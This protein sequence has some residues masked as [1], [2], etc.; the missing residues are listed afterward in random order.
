MSCCNFLFWQPLVK[1]KLKNVF[2]QF[3][4]VS[5]FNLFKVQKRSIPEAKELLL[6]STCRK[7]NSGRD[8]RTVKNGQTCFWSPEKYLIQNCRT[9]IE[10]N[11][12]HYYCQENFLARLS[13][14]N[15]TWVILYDSCH[16]I[17]IAWLNNLFESRLLPKPWQR[18][19]KSSRFVQFRFVHIFGQNVC[20]SVRTKEYRNIEH[21]SWYLCWDSGLEVLAPSGPIFTRLGKFWNHSFLWYHVTWLMSHDWFTFHIKSHFLFLEWPLFYLQWFDVA[22]IEGEFTT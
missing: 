12:T 7:C 8:P 10:L 6:W 9:T 1:E 5:V 3:V 17:E 18:A 13:S 2:M 4:F 14:K 19:G 20:K 15:L 11:A 22:E 16:M 21:R